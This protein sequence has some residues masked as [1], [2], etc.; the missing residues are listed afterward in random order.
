MWG[1]T[2]LAG[3]VLRSGARFTPPA[4]ADSTSPAP[5]YLEQYRVPCAPEVYYIPDFVTE[6]EEEYLLRKVRLPSD[7]LLVQNFMS[8]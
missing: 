8:S 6:H 1:R 4:M 7:T 3:G 5:N 2:S